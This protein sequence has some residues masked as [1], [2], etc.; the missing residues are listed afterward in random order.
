MAL[1]TEKASRE[2]PTSDSKPG[3]PAAPTEATAQIRS[4]LAE[5]IR[6]NGQL[7]SRIKVADA[8]LVKLRAKSKADGK[9]IDELSRE[10]TGLAQK[11]K[12]RVEELK[13]KAKLLDVRSSLWLVSGGCSHVQG[14]SR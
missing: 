7:Q 3:T 4:D 12:D 9:L 6:S 11:T 2:T 8:E 5:A 13:G 14:C 1:E 10:R